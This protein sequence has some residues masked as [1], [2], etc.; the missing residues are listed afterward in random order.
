MVGIWHLIEVSVYYIYIHLPS[1][2]RLHSYGEKITM[3]CGHSEPCL[4]NSPI[5]AQW[6]HAMGIFPIKLRIITMTIS[7][8]IVGIMPMIIHHEFPSKPYILHSICNRFWLVVAKPLWKIWGRQLGWWHQPNINGK[9][10]KMAT[11]CHQPEYWLVGAILCCSHGCS[12]HNWSLESWCHGLEPDE[13]Y[14][15]SLPTLK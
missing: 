4:R 7:Y 15:Q 8:K 1:R 13:S 12:P 14:Q 11:S 2:K 3:S 6:V 5:Q 9:M 10:P